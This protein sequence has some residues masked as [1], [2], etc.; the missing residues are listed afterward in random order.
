MKFNKN[1]Q[2]NWLWQR[3]RPNPLKNSFQLDLSIKY[4]QLNKNMQIETFGKKYMIYFL[5]SWMKY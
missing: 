3:F 4:I 1:N 2:Q 5:G